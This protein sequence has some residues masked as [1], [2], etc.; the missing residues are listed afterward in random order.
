MTQHPFGDSIS[1]G[2]DRVKVRD[3]SRIA[4]PAMDKLAYAAVFGGD[5]E[6]D[7]A[8]WLIWEIA[9]SGGVRP[10]SIHDLYLA[11]GRGETGG[12]PVPPPQLPGM[13]ADTARPRSAATVFCRSTP[14]LFS[15]PCSGRRR[16]MVSRRA[17][18]AFVAPVRPPA[19]A[20]CLW[21]WGAPNWKTSSPNGI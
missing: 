12:S 15:G 8:R 10:S 20:I 14:R 5:D 3:A 6:R 13:A 11:R 7:D 2:A 1:V 16:C 19:C 9:Q 4:S 21:V 18:R 17:P